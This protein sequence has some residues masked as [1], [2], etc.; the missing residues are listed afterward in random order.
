MKEEAPS[1][2]FERFF[3]FYIEA[4]LKRKKMND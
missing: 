1:D 3:T 2:T 4:I